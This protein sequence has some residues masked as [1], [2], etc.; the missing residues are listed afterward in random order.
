VNSVSHV[1]RTIATCI[2]LALSAAA[3]GGSAATGA[4]ATRGG[5]RGG[6][7]GRGE[8]AIPVV[9]GKVTERDVPVDISAIG[10]VEAYETVSVR[11][12]V[13]GIVSLVSFREGEFVKTGDQLFSIDPR[14]YQAM[15]QQAQANLLRDHALLSQA[16][17]QLSRDQAQAD[18]SELVAKR[19]GE[20]VE[21]GI[22]SK[23][24]AQQAQSAAKALA[25]TVR[26][27][28]AAIE[29]ARAQLGAQEAAVE[30]AKVQLGYT[31]IRS[32]INGRTGN[33]VMKIGNLATANVTE[34]VTIA[35]VEPTYVTFAVPSTHLPTI[36]GHIGSAAGG[37]PLEV[38]AT[39]QDA[40][41]TSVTGKLAFV[42]NSV[43]TATDT[44]KLKAVFDNHDHSL[45]P[46]QFARVKLR[47]TTLPHAK[48]VSSQAV[49]TGQDG[50]FVFVVKPDLTV[51]QRPVTVL[52]RVDDDVVISQGLE[53]GETIVT[54]GQ[55][56]LEPGSR[57]QSPEGR[58]GEGR[59]G[60]GP[61]GGPA[62]GGR[63]NR[64]Q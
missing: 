10:N 1:S 64:A 50:Q 26:A 2:V 7:G 43:D 22:V 38:V 8:G 32:P 25:E 4:S 29:S 53:T 17:A 15:L 62:R 61:S 45:W 56:R 54:E 46:G 31:T 14:L 3:C 24:T 49:Q 60:E 47:L 37:K 36:R 21:R 16:E 20:L 30:N 59:G 18:Y 6:R 5:G 44:I 63:G 9:T 41:A 28:K 58:G 40:T 27:D 11:S 35:Q 13:T 12:Q 52:Q 57:I 48:V 23:D 34:L 33:L 39:P 19:N 51:E 42:D 55:L